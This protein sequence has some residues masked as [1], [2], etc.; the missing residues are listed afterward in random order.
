MNDGRNDQPDDGTLPYRRSDFPPDGLRCF[1]PYNANTLSD[2]ALCYKYWIAL[3]DCDGFRI[4][5]VKHV[6]VDIA[7]AFCGSIKEFAD[8][9]GKHDFFL[10]SEIGGGDTIEREYLDE[11]NANK[12]NAALDIGDARKT[13]RLVGKGLEKPRDYFARY[14]G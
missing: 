13:L 7:R 4:D 11:I 3:T 14:V 12:M 8:V 10:V 2:L 1:N 9:L 6:A 5:T